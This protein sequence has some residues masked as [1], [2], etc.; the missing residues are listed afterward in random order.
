MA[1]CV[2]DRANSVSTGDTLYGPRI[3]NQAFSDWAWDAFDFDKGDWD[4]G[5]GF[6]NFCDYEWPLGRTYAG[7]WCLTYSAGP[8]PNPAIDTNTPIL[9]WGWRYAQNELDE[10]DGRCTNGSYVAL[11]HWGGAFVDDWTQLYLSFF[12]EAVPL[13]AG[14]LL[15]EARHPGGKKHDA[16]NNDSSWAY[17][18]AWR[19]HVVW[20]WWFWDRGQSTT[21]TMRTLARQKANAILSSKFTTPPGFT[22]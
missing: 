15:H 6:D 19:W 10:L 1:D 8:K 17:N 2:W 12:N 7:L 22:I 16:G 13:R 5:W 3:C 9:E 14:T 21:L 4:D 20:L 18:G 11:T